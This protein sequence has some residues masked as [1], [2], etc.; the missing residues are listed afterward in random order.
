ML[1]GISVILGQCY[2]FLLKVYAIWPICFTRP[3]LHLFVFIIYFDYN[4]FFVFYF[5]FWFKF[6]STNVFSNKD[7]KGIIIK[8][9]LK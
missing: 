6:K 4:H 9:W 5:L 1:Y 7:T 3:I 2:T 8:K